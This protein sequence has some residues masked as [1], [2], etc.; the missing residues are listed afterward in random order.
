V[1]AAEK[2]KQWCKTCGRATITWMDV[3]HCSRCADHDPEH[4]DIP[5]VGLRD[6]ESDDDWDSEE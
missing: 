2:L 3:S 5:G 1:R 4:P 6:D